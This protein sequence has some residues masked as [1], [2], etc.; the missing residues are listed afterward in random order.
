[1]CW[2]Q[3]MISCLINVGSSKLRDKADVRRQSSK[4][5]ALEQDLGGWIYRCC[6]KFMRIR[7]RPDKG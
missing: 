2:V 3:M 4:G 1:M 6:C 5:S 7:R